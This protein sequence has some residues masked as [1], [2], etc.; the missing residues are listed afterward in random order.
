MYP[1]SMLFGGIFAVIF[2]ACMAIGALIAIKRGFFLSILRLATLVVS[3]FASIPLTLLVAAKC[4]GLYEQI[5]YSILGESLDQIA[6]YSPSTMDLLQ[7]FPAAIIAPALFVTIFFLLSA[8]TKIICRLLKAI[9]PSHSNL[10]FRILGG[11]TGALS[12]L[13]CLLALTVPLW[14][15]VSTVHKAIDI[16]AHSDTS[17]NDQ[18]EAIVQQVETIDSSILGPAVDNFTAEL[19]TQK[20]DSALYR[21]LTQFQFHQ[22]TLFLSEEINLL[23]QTASDALTFAS[24]LAGELHINDL[25][26][27]QF[28]NLHTL[29]ADVDH[30]RLLRS[31]CAEWLS[32]VASTWQ[33]GEDFMGMAPIQVDPSAKPLMDA[34]YGYLSSTNEDR[35]A[36]DFDCFIDILEIMNKHNVL[37]EDE[38]ANLLTKIGN[39]AFV[40]DL[41]AFLN[42]NDRLRITIADLLSAIS[43]AWQNGEDYEG[44]KLPKT[45]ELFDPVM[46]TFFGILATTD[47][48]LITDDMTAVS[49]II[50]VLE[51]YDLFDGIKQGTDMAN[52]IME[53]AFVSDLQT[54][55]NSHPRFVPLLDTVTALGLSA[56][57]SQLN[58]SLPDSET[59]TQLA[60][61]ISSTLNTAKDENGNINLD[62]VS[63]EVQKTLKENKVD[64]PDSVTGMIAQVATE[65]FADQETVSE[66]EVK[67]HLL[68]LYG[69]AGD[70]DGFFQ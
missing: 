51:E 27:E 20:G 32:S 17:Q 7:H 9:M 35:I 54:E 29:T 50:G 31:I 4:I 45:N 30:S 68:S 60:D 67:D 47:D 63:E 23:S 38:S 21:K 57:S 55:I 48:T 34:L 15:T 22:E 5:M 39:E 36:A 44:I 19:F 33:K 69:S 8:V 16:I 14:G 62:T 56:I 11:V 25:T 10:T 53:G 28:A 18:L 64:V 65:K 1:N 43:G 59:L 42:V 61:T 12:T 58:I 13:V 70:L 3:F 26:E 49:N 6:Q 46:N 24:S 41:T 66:Q 37:S 40:Q 2:L 52:I